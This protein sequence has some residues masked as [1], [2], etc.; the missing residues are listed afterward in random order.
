MHTVHLFGGRVKVILVLYPT[1][2]QPVARLRHKG[3]RLRHSGPGE[4]PQATFP[5]LKFS[6][7]TGSLYHSAS[8]VALRQLSVSGADTR[9]PSNPPQGGVTSLG[10][11]PVCLC[12]KRF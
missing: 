6:I 7:K 4:R 12:C 9:C 8:G 3:A 11:L 2:A 5:T 10:A 1:P